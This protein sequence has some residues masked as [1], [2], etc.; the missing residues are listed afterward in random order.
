MDV[1]TSSR[2]A[3][4]RQIALAG[5]VAAAIAAWPGA[6]ARSAPPAS[7]ADSKPE[8]V[9]LDYTLKDMS[10]KDVR[11]A[12]YVGKP[13]ILNFWATW[14][15]PCKEEIP[16]LIAIADKYKDRGLTILGVSID[17][18][19]ADLQKFAAEHGMT[20]PILVG[21]GHDDMLENFEATFAVPVS[22]FIKADGSVFLKH[23]GAGSRDWFDEQ[24]KALF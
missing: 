5:L 6:C 21:Q 22:W 9:K 24:V 3:W 12:E 11:L 14:C 1:R 2:A 17:D 20:Y 16:S 23:E 10:G 19:P 13:I 8:R 4:T 7:T 18:S 15:E